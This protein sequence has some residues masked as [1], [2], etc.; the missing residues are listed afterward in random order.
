MPLDGKF[1]F[2]QVAIALATEGIESALLDARWNTLIHDLTRIPPD[3][4]TPAIIHC[5]KQDR[6]AGL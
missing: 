1:P 2:D 3:L 6:A 5:Q 4:L